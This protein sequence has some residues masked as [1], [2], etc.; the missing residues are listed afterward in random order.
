MKNWL[1]ARKRLFAGERRIRV[2]TLCVP[3]T[4]QLS[5]VFAGADQQAIASLLAKMG[6][7]EFEFIC[8]VHVFKSNYIRKLSIT[9]SICCGPVLKS[10]VIL[11]GHFEAADNRGQSPVSNTDSQAVA[12]ILR[13]ESFMSAFP[14]CTAV[15]RT[16][17]SSLED[18][19]D[20]M[21]NACQDMMN[22]YATQVPASQR[23]GAL[24]VPSAL[25]LVPLFTLSMLKSVSK[26]FRPVQARLFCCFCLFAVFMCVWGVSFFLALVL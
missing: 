2:H 12:P 21:M 7:Y 10:L 1:T 22:A 14:V 19:R 4:N 5:D 25:R 9:V 20:A 18:A 26:G 17:S 3:I 24:V 11:C 8:E 13:T 6:R 23:V 16:I 15:D